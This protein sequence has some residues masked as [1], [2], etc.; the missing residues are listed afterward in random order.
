MHYKMINLDSITNKNNKARNKKWP[1]IPDHPYRIL[2][3]RCPGSGK[4]NAFFNLIKEKHNIDQIY[5]YKK[6]LSQT[7]Y[8]FWIKKREDVG[9]KHLNDPETLSIIMQWMTFIRIFMSTTQAE[10]EKS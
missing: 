5:L 10:K 6:D 2:I 4:T 1:F 9:T 8:E 7:K 3:I